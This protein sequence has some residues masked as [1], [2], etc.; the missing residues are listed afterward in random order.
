MRLKE[1]NDRISSIEIILTARPLSAFSEPYERLIS[2]SADEELKVIADC[3]NDTCTKGVMVFSSC[4]LQSAIESALQSDGTFVL[5]EQ[6]DGWEDKKR[7]GKYHC[8]SWF[9]L[10]GRILMAQRSHEVG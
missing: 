7:I 9:T 8:N 4:E 5:K 2:I 10:N 3:P 6:C 1:I